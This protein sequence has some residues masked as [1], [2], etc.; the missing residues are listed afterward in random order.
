MKKNKD[1]FFYKTV[2]KHRFSL[3]SLVI[4][5]AMYMIVSVY[6]TP[7]STVRMSTAALT[8][9]V[10]GLVGGEFS[11]KNQEGKTVSEEMLLGKAS[12]VFFGFTHCPDICPTALSELNTVYESIPFQARKDV[13][14]IFVTLDPK[15]DT[16]DHL[17]DYMHAFNRD[18]IALRGTENETQQIASNFAV[19]YTFEEPNE[20]GDYNVNHTGFIY[21]MNHEG[22]Y[23]KHFKHNENGRLILQNLL[24]EAAKVRT[25]REKEATKK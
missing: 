22:N 13:Q 12:L 10:A 17:K 11:M 6:Y 7:N 25:A 19:Y 18:F 1:T 9:N 3:L 24:I 23:V 14:I 21:L 4:I 20:H 16:K 5:L 8:G 15:R 2:F